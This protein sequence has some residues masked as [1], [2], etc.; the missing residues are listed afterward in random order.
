V[1]TFHIRNTG[2]GAQAIVNG[3]YFYNYPPE[4]S[5]IA[6]RLYGEPLQLSNDEYARALDL[7][8]NGR[9]AVDAEFA[10]LPSQIPL[11]VQGASEDFIRSVR[12]VIV[13]NNNQAASQLSGIIAT[14]RD[15]TKQ[16]VTTEANRVIAS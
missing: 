6:T 5:Q 16:W 15:N 14:A 3:G 2:N 8:L 7:H 1:T 12:D 4:C 11:T 9:T 10:A 13:T